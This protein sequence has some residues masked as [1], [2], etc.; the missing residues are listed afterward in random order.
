MASNTE[1]LNLLIKDPSVDGADTFNVNTMLNENWKKID[2]FAGTVAQT[3]ANI[4]QPTTAAQIGLPPSA[5]PDDMFRA[6]GNTGELHVWRK[7]VV[8]AEEIP[9]G[10][11]LGTSSAK[12][13]A[14]SSKNSGNSYAVFY[15]SSGISVDDAGN[16]TLNE[17]TTVDIL[18]SFQS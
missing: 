2:Q 11:T 9:A 18:Q 3:L 1:N 4:L 15:V 7:T 14:K 6:L 13:L 10:Y 12:T 5:T 8:T 16:V 17:P